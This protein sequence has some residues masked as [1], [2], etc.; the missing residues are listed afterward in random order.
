VIAAAALAFVLLLAVPIEAL[1]RSRS[2]RPPRAQATR[3]RITIAKA[4]LLLLALL[5]VAWENGISAAELGIGFRLGTGGW[6][7]LALA[8]FVVTGLTTA[9]LLA[10]T[11]RAKF[12]NRQT[13]ELMPEGSVERRL[14]VVLVPLL[15]F[16][17]E[18][19]FR[20]YLLWWLVPITGTVAAVPI[21]SVAYGVAH[22]WS[23][24]RDGFASIGAALA[25][26]TAYALTG[27][28]W[29]L[30]IIHSAL[31]LI[32]YRAYRRAALAEHSVQELQAA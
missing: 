8:G 4:Y 2:K 26:T 29:W 5:V 12:R 10:K 16:A 23:N 15:G 18:I 17:W 7:G 28:L 14:F 9:A 6:V 3:F 19:L 32:G 13:N 25:F 30:M 31:P 11:D 21:A 20:G 1:F 24:N 22:G 27:S